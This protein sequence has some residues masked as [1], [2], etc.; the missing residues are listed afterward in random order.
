M[1]FSE[2][3][4]DKLLH[5]KILRSPHS[6]HCTLALTDALPLIVNVQVLALLPPLEHAPDQIAS[7]PFET[8]R[9]IAVPVAKA[10]E[11]L[12]PTL[13]LMPAGLD[14]TR[15]P[16]RPLALTVKVTPVPGGFTVSVA[17]LVTPASTAEMVAAVAAVTGLVVTV[18]VAPV[19]PAGTVMLAGTAAA[20]ELS[21]SVTSA[22][23]VGAAPV[24]VTLPCVVPPPVTLAGFTDTLD[25]LATAGAVAACG[26]KRRVLEYGPNTP[27][28]LRART[29]HH[30]RC[31]GRPPMLTWETL[32]T[33]FARK[34]AEI[35]EESST[36]IS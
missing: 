33:W 3:M 25:R 16:L 8:L 35:V 23:P 7:R 28:E 22:P 6:P 13:T 15:S 17:V 29:R 9:T 30:K 21:D 5:R 26:T 11:P 14:V 27:A 34:G 19:A 31:A 2:V 32:T 20:V 4:V 18:K 10:A 36:W 1:Q 12:L 24:S